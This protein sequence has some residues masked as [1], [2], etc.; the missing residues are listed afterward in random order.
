LT[1][2]ALIL[3]SIVS[4]QTDPTFPD[5]E[6]TR[7]E[8]KR[9]L[10]LIQAGMDARR[11][12]VSEWDGYKLHSQ[13]GNGEEAERSLKR[14]LI[15][16][17]TKNAKLSEAIRATRVL[18]NV[19]PTN[20]KRRVQSGPFQGAD[21]AF[22]P[23][24]YDRDRQFRKVRGPDGAVHYY[25]A[26]FD[27]KPDLAGV[28]W[29]D[30]KVI[31][32]PRVFEDALADGNPGVLGT[33]LY[34]EANHFNELMTY[35]GWDTIQAGEVRSYDKQLDR[36]GMFRLGTDRFAALRRERDAN[37]EI[38]DRHPDKI[39]PA[40]P[41]PEQE[42]WVKAQFEIDQAAL[43][44]I[45]DDREAFLAS[46]A[47]GRA[48]AQAQQAEDARL[49][50][51]R[52]QAVREWDGQAAAA[53][54]NLR[55][56]AWINEMARQ[57]K[58]MCADDLKGVGPKLGAFAKAWKDLKEL[59]RTETEAG[60][61]PSVDEDD[62]FDRF[63]EGFCERA[64]ISAV[65]TR[66]DPTSAYHNAVDEAWAVKKLSSI[67]GIPVPQSAAGQSGQDGQPRRDS[68]EGGRSGQD[69][70]LNGSGWRDLNRWRR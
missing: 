54:V 47:R 3:A 40:Y 68:D 60:R 42:V 31:V 11:R 43:K 10:A 70:G 24:F 46:R 51:A 29:P 22:R 65:F 49:G 12:E 58:A 28:T 13:A 33:L 16:E 61:R 32:L 7:G 50:A 36:A 4:A 18:F 69:P 34:H 35:K 19:E 48:A 26:Y 38:L 37:Q 39:L 17:R 57:A 67:R 1:R 20:A 52:E 2:L 63:P 53:S 15:A 5:P 45:R 59:Y 66:V 6:K 25:G 21:V 62:V 14:A 55:C 23:E 44:K 41:P 27:D 8:Q 56:D 9:I 30:G 64:I